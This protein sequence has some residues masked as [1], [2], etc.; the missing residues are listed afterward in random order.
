[1]AVPAFCDDNEASFLLLILPNDTR[2]YGDL[3]Q[4]PSIRTRGTE[5]RGGCED[6]GGGVTEMNQWGVYV[7]INSVG[8]IAS[9]E[10]PLRRIRTLIIMNHLLIKR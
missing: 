10:G 7:C 2:I 1:M 3:H 5:H 8:L 4:Q 6:G 9:T